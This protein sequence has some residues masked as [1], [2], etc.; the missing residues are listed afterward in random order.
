VVKHA[1]VDNYCG[2][3]RM[4]FLKHADMAALIS[5]IEILYFEI[6]ELTQIIQIGWRPVAI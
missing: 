3:A 4:I 5:E 2:G 1:L 6:L